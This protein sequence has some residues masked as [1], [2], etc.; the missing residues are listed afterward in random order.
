M[1]PLDKSDLAFYRARSRTCAVDP[2]PFDE[3]TSD[4]VDNVTFRCS[5]QN[6]KLFNIT[7]T[8]PTQ[9]KVKYVMYKY[10]Y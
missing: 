4:A 8:Q 5:G 1:D 3:G 9:N 10:A 6:R 2:H 7:S